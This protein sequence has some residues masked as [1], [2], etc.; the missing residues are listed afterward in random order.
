[1]DILGFRLAIDNNEIFP[2]TCPH[3]KTNVCVRLNK[4]VDKFTD[5]ADCK[6]TCLKRL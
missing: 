1:M 6:S 2:W 4:Y 5:K 3:N